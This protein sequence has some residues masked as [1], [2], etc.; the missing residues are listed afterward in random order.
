V[1]VVS[2]V[3]HDLLQICGQGIGNVMGKSFHRNNKLLGIYKSFD[4]DLQLKL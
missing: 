1:N 2:V 3:L 4:M